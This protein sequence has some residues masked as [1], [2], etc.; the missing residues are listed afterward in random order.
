LLL[1]REVSPIRWRTTPPNRA[2]GC[3][4]RRNCSAS[5]RKVSWVSIEEVDRQ[6]SAGRRLPPGNVIGRRGVV[7]GRQG[8]GD[9]PQQAA[10]F[11][12]K[13]PFANVP[14]GDLVASL[15]HPPNAAL[16]ASCFEP[17]RQSRGYC[18][19]RH[20]AIPFRF[21]PERLNRAMIGELFGRVIIR[22]RRFDA[23]FLVGDQVAA[24]R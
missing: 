12:P 7:V 8:G 14:N 20:S 13:L 6:R 9:V 22:F 11:E 4:C 21:G 1:G 19:F 5:V 23:L 15:R 24:D 18:G 10:H 17:C 2:R 16:G 3:S